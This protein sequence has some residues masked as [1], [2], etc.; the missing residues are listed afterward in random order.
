LGAC[1]HGVYTHLIVHKLDRLGRIS[2]IL[3]TIE[4][5]DIVFVSVQDKVDASTAAGR[6][7]ITIC[8]AIAQWRSDNLSE[9]ARKGK[10]GRKLAGLYNG[11]NGRRQRGNRC[12]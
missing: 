11:D 2:Q 12:R 6:L 8:L 9:E 5:H 7:H 3:E 1:I 4:A 10:E